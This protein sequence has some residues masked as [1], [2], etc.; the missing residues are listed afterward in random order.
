MRFNELPAKTP[1]TAGEPAP[2]TKKAFVA[3]YFFASFQSRN[4]QLSRAAS[5]SVMV[6]NQLLRIVKIENWKAPARRFAPFVTSS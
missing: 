2:D 1:T 4:D 5:D 3:I 6:T